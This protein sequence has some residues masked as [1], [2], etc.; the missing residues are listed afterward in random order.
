[1][2]LLID[3]V[4]RIHPR[5]GDRPAAKRERRPFPPVGDEDDAPQDPAE[6]SSHRRPSTPP[7]EAEEEP[8]EHLVD[9]TVLGRFLPSG[10]F[11]PGRD[12]AVM[13]Q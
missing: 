8:D 4:D 13:R 10:Q 7:P 6:P 5:V 1:M 9:I 11:L 12:D 2:I 3:K